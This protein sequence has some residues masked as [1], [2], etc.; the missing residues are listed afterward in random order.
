VVDAGPPSSMASMVFGPGPG[1]GCRTEEL[2]PER[3]SVGALVT[4]ETECAVTD[5]VQKT[6]LRGLFSF[7]VEVL[8]VPLESGMLRHDKP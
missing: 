5:A 3:I 4:N 7:E 1:A 2:R 6:S 8:R